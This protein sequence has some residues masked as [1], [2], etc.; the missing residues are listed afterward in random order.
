VSSDYD[1]RL[2]TSIPDVLWPQQIAFLFGGTAIHKGWLACVVGAGAL[3]GQ[4]IGGFLCQYI[5]QSRW[6]LIGSALSLL[7]FSAAMVSINVGDESKGVALMFMATVSVGVLEDCSLALAPL[8]LPTE[9]IGAALGALG[10]IRSGGAAVALAIYVTILTNKLTQFVPPRV[11]EAVTALGLPVSSVPAL[12]T[13]LT[14]G[15]G[16]D[17]VP[18]ADPSIIAA[19]AAA[20]SGAAADAF[21]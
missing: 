15:V 4:I 13:A 8:A 21:R 18:G 7:A 1:V 20:Q 11:T 12:L 9:D 14:T 5:K 17:E 3:V 19:A 16:L 10:S 2:L 6:I